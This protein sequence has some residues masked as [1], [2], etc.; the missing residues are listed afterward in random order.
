[1][2][3][4]LKVPHDPGPGALAAP[5]PVFLSDIFSF[6]IVGIYWNNNHHHMLHSAKH[7]WV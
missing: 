4:E 7:V 3:L 1:M 5:W 2:V 6:V